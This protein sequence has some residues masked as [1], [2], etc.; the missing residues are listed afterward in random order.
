MNLT[1]IE[2][3]K[4]LE[5]GKCRVFYYGSFAYGGKPPLQAIAL[6]DW[7]GTPNMNSILCNSNETLGEFLKSDN[8]S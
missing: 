3:L 4:I 1:Q 7:N 8:E 5:D 2:Y 6:K